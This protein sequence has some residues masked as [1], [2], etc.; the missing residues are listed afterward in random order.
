MG[1]CCGGIEIST[2]LTS[3]GRLRRNGLLPSAKLLTLI[4]ARNG[5]YI[6]GTFDREGEDASLPVFD[7]WVTADTALR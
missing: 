6:G 1:Y 3:L 2:A 4:N 7:S 5:S